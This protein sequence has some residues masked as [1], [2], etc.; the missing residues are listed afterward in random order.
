[1]NE[2]NILFSVYLLKCFML[3]LRNRIVSASVCPL[4]LGFVVLQF[5]GLSILGFIEYE[6]IYR[7]FDYLD[8]GEGY[9]SPSLMG[10]SAAIMIVGYHVL[11]ERFPSNIAVRFIEGIVRILIPLY[12]IGAGLYI[13]SMLFNDE[14]ASMSAN[15]NVAIA[16][17]Q[18]PEQ[19]AD[20]GWLE[21]LFSNVTSPLGVAGFSLGIGGLAIVNIFVA[22][23]L[24]TQIKDN[25]GGIFMRLKSAKEAVGA[26]KDIKRA[27]RE[28]AQASLDLGDLA[29]KNEAYLILQIAS[30]TL[31]II[32]DELIPHKIW[33]KDHQSKTT[34]EFEQALPADPK[35][36]AKDI[37]AIES[38]TQAEIIS[39]LNPQYLEDL[40]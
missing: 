25:I 37:A 3:T 13:A 38:I 14:I 5:A 4:I 36:V 32:A 1:M 10:L 18:I 28:Y 29:V 26:Y 17:G 33:L 31:G 21:W 34:H 22:H 24:L 9:W 39:A 11:A 15:A 35:Q 20:R 6:I 19:V 12:L 2:E 7:V 40:R 30:E 8:G 16:I 23:F 27:Q